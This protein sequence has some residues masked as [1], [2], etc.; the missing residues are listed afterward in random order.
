MSTRLAI[1][2]GAP[3]LAAVAAA[4]YVRLTPMPAEDWHADPTLGARTGKPNDYLMGPDGDRPALRV[5]LPPDAVLAR[6]EAVALAEPN[7]SRL[8]GAPDDGW[9]TYVQRSRLMAFPDAIS[10]RAVPDG[11][12]SRLSI[13]SRSRYGYGDLGVNAARVARWL[14]AAGLDD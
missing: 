12:G 2:L 13:W 4:A 8:A 3:L 6:I 9:A 7:T 14:R 10:V 5:D 1:L 11:G